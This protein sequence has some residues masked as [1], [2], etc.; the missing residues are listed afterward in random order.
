MAKVT[1]TLIANITSEEDSTSNVPI[2][3]SN[4]NPNFDATFADFSTYVKMGAS[5]F[6][7]PVNAYGAPCTQFY[8]KNLDPT[9]MITLSWT[10]QGQ[11]LVR[12]LDLYPGDSIVFW[13][14]PANDTAGITSAQI[15]FASGSPLIEYFIGG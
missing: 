7:L 5:P 9:I 12:V 11:A 2:N 10:P 4:G 14:N 1:N 8:L 15:S 6:Q 3:R 13:E